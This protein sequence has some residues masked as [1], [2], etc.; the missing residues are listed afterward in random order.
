MKLR[1]PFHQAALYFLLTVAAAVLS[2]FGSV[3]GWEGVDNALSAEGLRWWLRTA[4][5]GYV[6]SPFTEALLVLSFGVGL[7]CDT[8]LWRV[9]RDA[10]RHG[11]RPTRRER[12]GLAAAAVAFA[13]YAVL[14][15]V[16][17]VIPGGI[18]SSVT[19]AFVGSPLMDGA[20]VLS[21]LCLCVTAVVY[22]Y[23]IDT[24]GSH[25]HIIRGMQSGLRL[26]APCL[27]T[28]IFVIWFFSVLRFTGLAACAGVPERAVSL[29]HYV[30]CLFTLAEAG[31]G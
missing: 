9:V 22:A 6:R 3:Y 7:W 8:G 30:C 4:A 20:A 2:W 13:L 28:L 19:G 23:N 31:R 25:R 12:R 10:V 24:Y 21:S 27:V 15:A 16:M 17:A 1:P 11:R 18:A 5:S 29:L 26:F 14:L